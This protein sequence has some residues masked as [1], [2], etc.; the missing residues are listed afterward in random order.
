MESQPNRSQEIPKSEVIDQMVEWIYH[1]GIFR[2]AL[3][4]RLWEKIVAGEDT[5]EGMA[6]QEGWNLYGTRILLDAIC[7]L[8]LLSKEDEHYSLVPES[9][10]YLLPGKPT[11]KGNIPQ[12]EFNW[13]GNGKLTEAIC[14]E[15]CP[16][17]SDA[18]TADVINLWIAACCRQML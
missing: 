1:I 17:F 16:L 18:T 15:K 8:K 3:D 2:A 7:A 13:E 11:Y 12:T 10:Y 14:S 4:L 6:T 9:A 5:A